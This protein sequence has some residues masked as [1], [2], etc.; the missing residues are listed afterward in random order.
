MMATPK[1]RQPMRE[2]L[3]E[4]KNSWDPVPPLHQGQLFCCPSET[5]PDPRAQGVPI[6]LAAAIACVSMGFYLLSPLK[7]VPL[8]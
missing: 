2:V 1:Q 3:C 5:S 6:T 4:S 8:W 7:K